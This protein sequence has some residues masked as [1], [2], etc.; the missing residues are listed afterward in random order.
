MQYILKTRAETL[1]A[2]LKNVNLVNQ[3]DLDGII[4]QHV[5]KRVP[6]QGKMKRILIELA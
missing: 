6:S 5:L 4:T 3:S 2:T 1:K